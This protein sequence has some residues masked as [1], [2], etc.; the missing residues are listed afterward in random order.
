MMRLTVDLILIKNSTRRP[1]EGIGA[2]VGGNVE[3]LHLPAT[4][5]VAV[6]NSV[7]HVRDE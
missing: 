2:G 6:P 7:R 5:V 4:V 3:E 1:A